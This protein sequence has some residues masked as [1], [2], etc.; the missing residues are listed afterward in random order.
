MF[1]KTHIINLR[2]SIKAELLYAKTHKRK[3]LK[4]IRHIS[5]ITHSYLQYET[6]D[7]YISGMAWPEAMTDVVP[8]QS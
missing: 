3:P 4:L 6:K 1:Y 2:D 7:S 8:S 5:Q